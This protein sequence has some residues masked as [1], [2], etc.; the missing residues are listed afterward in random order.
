MKQLLILIS[1]LWCYQPT[2]H[3]G[4]NGNDSVIQ[5]LS[6]LKNYDGRKFAAMD[7]FVHQPT[8]NTEVTYPLLPTN[9]FITTRC[10]PKSMQMTKQA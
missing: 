9:P 1:L 6:K 4:S 5:T 10:Q 3:A 7:Q 2:L 8:R